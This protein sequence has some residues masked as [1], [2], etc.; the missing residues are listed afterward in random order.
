MSKLK[1]SILLLSLFLSAVLLNGCGTTTGIRTMNAFSPKKVELQL[2]MSDLRYLGDAEVSVTYRTYL[3]L[4]IS[5]DQVNGEEYSPTNVKTTKFDKSV[6][7][8]WKLDKAAYKVIEQYPEADYYQVV[9]K[10]KVVERLFL[11]S[12]IVYTA[13]IQA[14][15]FVK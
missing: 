6:L 3:G 9:Y 4:F 12:E 11:G 13:R 8:D 2:H 5:I 7:R 15:S 14:Y 1:N 10:K